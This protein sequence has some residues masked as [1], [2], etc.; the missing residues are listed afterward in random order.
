MTSLNPVLTIGDQIGE[1]LRQHH[2]AAAAAL[3]ARACWSCSTQS[4]F[5]MSRAATRSIP[6]QLSGGMKQRVMIA[7]AL[8]GRPR[9]ADRRRADHGARRHDP[10]AGA[11]AA[12][13]AAA[14][15]RHGD[16]ADHPRSG[17]GGGD[18]RPRRRDVCR[19]D[20]RAGAARTL[21]QPR[22]AIPTAA[23]CSTRC[24]TRQARSG[25]D[26]DSGQRAAADQR[27]TGCRF[28]DRCDR[29][30]DR[31]RSEV[32]ALDDDRPRA[33]VRCHLVDT[34]RPAPAE[35][36]SLARASDIAAGRRRPRCSRSTT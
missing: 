33:G 30:W 35:T 7:I 14:R 28:A 22:R 17:R 15:T 5:P 9:S 4:A 31:C 3:P 8:A 29:V 2:G 1:V 16:P 10:G 12:A 13:A 20:R 21:L 24:R 34:P 18:G 6:H 32:P 26:S 23:S 36:A 11:G 25:A 19:P 27:F